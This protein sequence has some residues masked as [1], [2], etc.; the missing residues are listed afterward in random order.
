MYRNPLPSSL[1]VPN[2]SIIINLNWIDFISPTIQKKRRTPLD[3]FRLLNFL[4]GNWSRFYQSNSNRFIP[5]FQKMIPSLNLG[6]GGRNWGA[7]RQRGKFWW[8]VDVFLFCF[9]VCTRPYLCRFFFF[10]L[11]KKGDKTAEENSKRT[12]I[13]NKRTSYQYFPTHPS[14]FFGFVCRLVCCHVEIKAEPR[15][16]SHTHTHTHTHTHRRHE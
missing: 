1:I 7:N 14:I 8:G 16:E 13:P 2:G 15:E 12:R 11:V 5:I 10:F 6:V 3:P 9:L 4:D